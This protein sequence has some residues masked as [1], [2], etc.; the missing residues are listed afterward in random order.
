MEDLLEEITKKSSKHTDSKTNEKDNFVNKIK[1]EERWDILC[2]YNE[3]KAYQDNTTIK[4]TF[5][6]QKRLAHHIKSIINFTK[7][8]QF[9]M[10]LRY[11]ELSI[12]ID[13]ESKLIHSNLSTD[14]GDFIYICFHEINEEKIELIEVDDEQKQRVEHTTHQSKY[15][16]EAFL[17]STSLIGS[18]GLLP[19]NVDPEKPISI[20]NWLSLTK[21]EKFPHIMQK[22]HYRTHKHSV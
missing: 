17:W 9:W 20:K 22:Y 1:D 2:G 15:S 8:S 3:D 5:D 14:D 19:D 21:V 18:H 12:M 16:N 13:P 11:Q 4:T 6:P 10:E 7:N